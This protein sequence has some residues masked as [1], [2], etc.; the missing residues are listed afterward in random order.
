MNIRLISSLAISLITV[1]PVSQSLADELIDL[2]LRLNDGDSYSCVMEMTQ[3]VSQTI[4]GDRQTLKQRMKTAWTYNVTGV[5]DIGVCDIEMIYDSIRVVQDFGFHTTEYDSQNPPSYIEPAMKGYTVLAGSRLEMRIDSGGRVLGMSG[6][7]ELIDKMLAEMD[8][9]DSPVK[10][11]I[12]SSLRMQFGEQALSE[13]IAQLTSF[14][15][16]VPVK[17]GDTWSS[18]MTIETGFPMRIKNEYDLLAVDDGSAVIKVES[19]IS[20]SADSAGINM[21]FV[22]IRNEIAG[23]Q[24]GTTEVDITS[25]LPVRSK[26]DMEFEGSVH[27][28]GI[29]DKEP[30]SW[31]IKADGS[32]VV[33]MEKK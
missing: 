4:D 17:P 6:A 30:R 25:G 12:V 27:V 8:L 28:S 11:R 21:G 24:S 2:R 15:P 7:E 13:S 33:T 23:T 20:S 1:L 19:M 3:N 5:D 32:V 18:E 31:P 9:P 16:P 10:D 29:S 14:Y 22:N 26:I